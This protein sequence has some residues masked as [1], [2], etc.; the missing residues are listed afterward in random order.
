MAGMDAH[1]HLFAPGQLLG[2]EQIAQGD[3]T[4]REMYGDP[5][6]KMAVARQLLQALDEAE[7]DSAVVAGFAFTHEPDLIEQ[8]EY[9]MEA[10]RV[11]GGRLVPLATVNPALP[12]W[13][14]VAHHALDLGAR[15]F[16]ELRP[17]NQGW[18]PLGE[19]GRRLCGL[20]K[21]SGLVLLWH[22]SEPVGH[23]YPGKFGGIAPSELVAIATA[24]PGLPMIAAHLGAGASFYLQMP[25][26]RSAI[27]SVYFDTAAASLLYDDV[28][29]ARLVDLTG[30]ERVLFG[31]DYP[32]LSPRRQIERLAAQLPGPV[33]EAV[34]GGNA[35]R[36]FSD[37]GTQ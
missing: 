3:R 4:F 23:A 12:G 22:C 6:A 19:Q 28:S 34:C 5:A 7:L 29:V 16:G 24:F 33:L 21:D 37:N 17:H 35:R 30:P 20:A 8:N 31:S 26:V 36:L 1:T 15:G 14:R 11:S 9:L 10:A 27:D 32:L 25:E 13:E 18:D 2:R